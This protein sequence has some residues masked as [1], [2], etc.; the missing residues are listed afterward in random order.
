MKRLFAVVGLTAFIAACSDS[1]MTAPVSRAQPHGAS[2]VASDP[3]PPPLSGAG[4]GFADAGN[5]EF[6]NFVANAA[7]SNQCNLFAEFDLEYVFKFLQNNNGNNTVG[8]LDLSGP[9]TGKIDVHAHANGKSDISG[10]ISN[11]S[12][13]LDI[14]SGDGTVGFNG[15]S[16]SFTGTLTDLSTGEKCTN[17]TGSAEGSLVSSG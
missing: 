8:H 11:G 6:G 1:N 4:S 16:F 5:D 2:R 7:Q 12:F 13:D 15:F 9:T 14:K 17:T 3:P 10:H